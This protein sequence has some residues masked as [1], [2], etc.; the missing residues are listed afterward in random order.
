MS[1]GRSAKQTL[2]RVLMLAA[3]AAVIWLVFRDLPWKEVGEA[4]RQISAWQIVVLLGLVLLRAVV[5]ALPMN[6]LMPE[7]SPAQATRNDLAGNLV[8]NFAPPPSDIGVRF[9]MFRSW[10]TNAG[11][12]MASLTLSAML[13]Y[14]GRFAAPLVGFVL[15]LL[16]RRYDDEYLLMALVAGLVSALII[17][18]IILMSRAH[19]TAA[20]LGR[21]AARIA[22][23]F[24]TVDPQA[25]EDGVLAFRERVNHRLQRGWAG[26]VLAV[27]ALLVLE[28]FILI[29]C[30]RFTGLPAEAVVAVE[31]AGAF[32]VTY[33]LNM[34]PFGG[35]IILDG[36]ILEILSA[37]GGA[38]YQAQIA[39]GLLVWRMATLI[40]PFLLGLLV[41][42]HW[43]RN[44]GQGVTWRE[45]PA[46]T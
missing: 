3:A 43:Q 7:V 12:A 42:L 41:L 22:G 32:L 40:T 1:Q 29:V 36:L 17:G 19:R 2:L 24:R 25:W 6:L 18:G 30:L 39:A 23:R 10:G 20:W 28:S 38:A 21:T 33:P 27:A 9:A 11:E 44:E 16:T 35:I 5:G 13:F 31:I 37:Q 34:L 14:A 26:A 8:A 15:I 45:R 46:P 4:V